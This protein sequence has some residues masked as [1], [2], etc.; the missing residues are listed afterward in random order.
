MFLV[1]NLNIITKY[2]YN[3]LHSAIASLLYFL[4]NIA[5]DG[6][7]AYKINIFLEQIK[8]CNLNNF[9]EFAILMNINLS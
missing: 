8:S 4:L 3:L 2:V 7:F 5:S 9:F 6:R 1:I